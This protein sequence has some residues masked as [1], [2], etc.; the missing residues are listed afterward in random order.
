MLLRIEQFAWGIRSQPNNDL[1]LVL[2]RMSEELLSH[3]IDA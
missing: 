1:F 2:T 3:H